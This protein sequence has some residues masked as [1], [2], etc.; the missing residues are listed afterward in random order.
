[1]KV[2]TKQMTIYTKQICRLR[3]QQPIF[4]NAA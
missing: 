2:D 4:T 3:K 1:V